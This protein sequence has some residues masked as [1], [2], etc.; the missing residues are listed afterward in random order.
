MSNPAA[1]EKV[2]IAH[3]VGTSG[4]KAVLTDLQGRILQTSYDSYRMTFPKPGWAEQDPDLLLRTVIRTTRQ[5]IQQSHIDPNRVAG[6]GI[7]AQMFNLIPVDERYQPLTSMLTWMDLRATAQAE[8]FLD[9]V[10][11]RRLC[12]WTGNVPNAKDILPKILWLRE[13]RPDLWA[14]TYQLLDCK[15]YLLYHLTGR[16]AVDWHGAT[17]F[18]LL[19][20]QTKA[21]SQPACQAAGIPI[22]M[23]P[24]PIPCTEVIGELLP[25]PAQA[26]GL[27]PGTP[28]VIC[29]GDI[30]V[31]QVGAGTVSPGYAN[32]YIGTGG[33][34]AVASQRL[35]NNPDRPFWALNHILPDDWIL[36]T[37]LDTAGGSLMWFRDALCQ[38]EIELAR[39]QGKTAYQLLSEMAE[40]VPPGAGELLYFP[41]LSGERGH[42][43]VGHHARGGFVGLTFGHTKAHMARA[44]MEGVAYFF[45]WMLTEFEENGV[46]V[47]VIKAIGGGVKS[48]TWLQIMSDVLDRELLV[49]ASPQEAGSVG[50]ALTVSAGLGFL[51]DLRQADDLVPISHTVAPHSDLRQA[52]YDALYQQFLEIGN[53]L[54]PHFKRLS[55]MR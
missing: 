36:S 23:L 40:S 53:D 32:L 42:M 44:V 1:P 15:E 51:P 16:C 54:Q 3:D 30:G 13:V 43:G 49:V 46:Q 2:L 9:E 22:Q 7:S 38:P 21:W 25:A 20:P 12:E 41:W 37:D 4:D 18:M 31:A 47:E 33:W 8:R 10:G 19:D 50:A 27:L 17:V 55:L 52:R 28:V 11:A 45:R 48:A 34:I 14:R 26:M 39:S 6:I 5:L 29:A 24:E 35:V